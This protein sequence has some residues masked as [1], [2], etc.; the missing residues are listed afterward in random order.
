[1]SMKA[2]L[3]KVLEGQ[4]ALLLLMH[5]TAYCCDSQPLPLTLYFQRSLRES[6]KPSGD[7]ARDNLRGEDRPATKTDRGECE[8]EGGGEV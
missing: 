3:S 5:F 1:M 2:T 4:N 8:R 6:A 7:Q